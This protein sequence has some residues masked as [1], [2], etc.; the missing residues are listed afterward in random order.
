MLD[1]I[2]TA[3]NGYA[4]VL[5]G[6]HITTFLIAFALFSFLFYSVAMVLFR[7]IKALTEKTKTTLDDILIDRARRPMKIFSI[8]L[9][10][11]VSLLWFYPEFNLAGHGTSEI[12][13]VLFIIAGTYTADRLIDGIMVWY[14]QE[15]APKTESKFDDEIYPLFRKIVRV[16]IYIVGFIILLNKL[17]IEI[18]AFIAGLGIAGL[19]VALALQD[20]LSNFFSGVYILADKP[21][22][23]GDYI[24]IEDATGIE[25]NVEEVGWRSTRIKTL[26][27]NIVFVP[28]SKLATSIITNFHAP[29][30][31]MGIALTFGAS[32]NDEPDKVVASLK[33]AVKNAVKNGSKILNPDTTVVR[34]DTF[35]DSSVN[36]KVVVKVPTYTDKYTVQ[37][38]LVR[39]VYYQFKKDGISIPFPTRTVYMEGDSGGKKELKLRKVRKA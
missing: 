32:Y 19:A 34:A 21:I 13:I 37:G 16:L 31:E 33:Q 3:I 8:L 27:G 35:G 18:S 15:I 28:N 36:Y 1:G 14:G 22:K 9:S 26:S 25:G 11:Y 2:L 23:P 4:G 39:E 30:E 7:A 17:G 5:P 10:A 12:F 29:S 6:G 20:T 38:E 24:K